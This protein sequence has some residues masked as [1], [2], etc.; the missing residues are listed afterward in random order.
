VEKKLQKLFEDVSQIFVKLTKGRSKD[1]KRGFSLWINLSPRAAIKVFVLNEQPI[2][3]EVTH[4]T[5]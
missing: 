2:C 4:F 3:L 5:F 1:Q